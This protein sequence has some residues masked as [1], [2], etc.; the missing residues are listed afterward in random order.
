MNREYSY[1]AVLYRK[2]DSVFEYLIIKDRNGNYSFPK[3]HRE[4]GE[5]EI[6][7]AVREIYEEVGIKA[8]P[9][10]FFVYGISYPLDEN[11]QK[12]VFYYM[13]DIRND[14]PFINDREV[15]NI[16]VLPYEEA[17]ET[18]TYDD[19]K[20][21]L[22]EVNDR[23][24]SNMKICCMIADEGSFDERNLEFVKYYGS[25]C[26]GHDLYTWDEGDRSLYRCRKCG[27]Y[28]LKQYSEIHMPDAIY[29]DYFPV[30]DEKHA[31]ELNEKYNGWSIETQY[32]YRKI[33]R[34]YSY[35]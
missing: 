19:L 5:S 15:Q 23:L 31:E 10:P 13:A 27:A 34:T 1:G 22:K 29:I 2:N 6:Q 33:F 11:T 17:Y 7:C 24:T 28:I 9:D 4:K 35:D 18:L 26:N 12:H 16:E 14:V 21:V 3:G 25:R 20:E 8:E 32:P 30:R